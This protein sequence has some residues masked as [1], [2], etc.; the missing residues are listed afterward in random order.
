MITYIIES[1][2]IYKIGKTE[3]IEYR[4]SC[5]RTHNP[6]FELIHVMEFDC[7]MFL[8]NHF[9]EK[10][11][12]LEWFYLDEDDI[13]WIRN[14]HSILEENTYDIIKQRREEKKKM[15]AIA[16]RTRMKEKMRLTREK[17]ILK[18]QLQDKEDE[19]WLLRKLKENSAI[20][21]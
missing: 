12:M 4:L 16:A 8:H 14:N 2:G 15:E 9:K 3:N 13:S 20:F 11:Y 10:Q 21:S 18:K 1:Q 5:Y 7:E 17:N 19:E 6:K